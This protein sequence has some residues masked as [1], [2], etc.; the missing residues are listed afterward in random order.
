[1]DRRAYG[2]T[3]DGLPDRGMFAVVPVLLYF[4]YSLYTVHLLT[5]SASAASCGDWPA[6]RRPTSFPLIS[7]ESSDLGLEFEL[8]GANIKRGIVEISR[9]I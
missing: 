5:D 7:L 3:I 8:I 1:M 9:V 2:V 4:F 6:S